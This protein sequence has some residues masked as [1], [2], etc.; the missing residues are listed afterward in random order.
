MKNK[1]KGLFASIFDQKTLKSIKKTEMFLIK[2]EK[3]TNI[4]FLSI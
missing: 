3:N 2:F 1:R 4:S